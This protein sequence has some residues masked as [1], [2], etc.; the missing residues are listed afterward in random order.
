MIAWHHM[1]QRSNMVTLTYSAGSW[2]LLAGRET[3]D[4]KWEN[5]PGEVA[6]P[7]TWLY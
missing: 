3:K 2:T 5:G 1:L 4:W 6:A 7:R